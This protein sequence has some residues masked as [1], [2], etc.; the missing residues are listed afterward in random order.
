[1]MWQTIK[2]DLIK[3]WPTIYRII[4]GSLYFVLN[5]IKSMVFYAIRQLKGEMY[6]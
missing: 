4:N 5:L 3:A 1:M 2:A 6:E